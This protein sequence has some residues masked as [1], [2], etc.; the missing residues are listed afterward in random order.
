MLRTTHAR[1]L[2]AVAFALFAL[3]AASPVAAVAGDGGG[4]NPTGA[5]KC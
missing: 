3:A 1:K 5:C 2:V 4:P